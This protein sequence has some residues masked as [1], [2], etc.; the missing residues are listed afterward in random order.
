MSQNHTQPEEIDFFL[1]EMKKGDG[2]I[3]S[4]KPITEK[5]RSNKLAPV[6]WCIS[7]NSA[8]RAVYLK[9]HIA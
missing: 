4:R 6:A 9:S 5:I 3:G 2:D 8:Y 7:R 1:K